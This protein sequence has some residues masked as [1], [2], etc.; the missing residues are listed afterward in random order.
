MQLP[1]ELQAARFKLLRTHPY[2][3]AAVWSMVPVESP[4]LGT[5]AVDKWGRLY[6]DPE[7]LRRWSPQERAGV[8][9]HEVSHI[10]RDHCGRLDSLTDSKEL[11]NIAG[12]MEINDDIKEETARWDKQR[13]G[14]PASLPEGAIYPS[15][16][17]LQDH[18]TAEQYLEALKRKSVKVVVK[19]GSGSHGQKE[20]WEEGPPGS[21]NGVHEGMGPAEMGVVRK[22]VAEAVKAEM[23]KGRGTIPGGLA[24]WAEAYLKPKVD[25]RRELRGAVRGAIGRATGK[26]DY[27]FTRPN[28]RSYAIG[29]ILPSLMKPVPKVAVVVDT[30]GSMGGDQLCRAKA[31]IDGVLRTV[32]ESIEVISLD[33]AVHARQ[34]VRHSGSVKLVGGGGTDMRLGFNAVAQC[35]PKPDVVVFITD[36]DTPWPQ[37][38]PVGMRTVVCLVGSGTSP[39]WARTVRVDCCS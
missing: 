29:V 24:R 20:D 17:Q 37:S 26:E 15:T 6:Y 8:L 30:S 28:R 32:G 13:F 2:L 9:Y 31:E 14:D 19:C 21:G 3:G 11:A 18:L 5:L 4:G 23:A 25:W 16:F 22:A 7:A 39:E 36:G 10:L 35:K 12:D 33:A 34:K 27:T 38:P 1:E